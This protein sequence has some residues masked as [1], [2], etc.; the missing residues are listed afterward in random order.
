MLDSL[1]ILI[2]VVV[3][4]YFKCSVG[5]CAGGTVWPGPGVLC[6]CIRFILA[7]FPLHTPPS[8]GTAEI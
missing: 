5:W 1:P 2:V 3:L 7:G 8:T 4:T 6:S